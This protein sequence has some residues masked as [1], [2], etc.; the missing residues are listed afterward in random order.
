[1]LNRASGVP[2]PLLLI[3]DDNAGNE[4]DAS[5]PCSGVLFSRAPTLKTSSGMASSVWCPVPSAWRA[6]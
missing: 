5:P 1:M 3:V 4:R 6:R 2:R